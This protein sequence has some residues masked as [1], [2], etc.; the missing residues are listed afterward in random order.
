[1]SCGSQAQIPNIKTLLRELGRTET[2]H[3]SYYYQFSKVVAQGRARRNSGVKAAGNTM[4]GVFLFPRV[5]FQTSI[6]QQMTPGSVY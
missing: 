1:M 6:S 2:Y 3:N 5:D 4:F